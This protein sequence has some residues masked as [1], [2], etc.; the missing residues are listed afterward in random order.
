MTTTHSTGDDLSVAERHLA[1]L[2][3]RLEVDAADRDL[4]D[5]AYRIIETPVGDVMVAAT[6]RG[7]VRVA[8]RVEGFDAVLTSLAARISPRVMSAPRRLDRVVGQLDEY[9][10]GT[11]RHFDVPLDWALSTGFRRIVHEH[12]PHIEFGT[13]TTY[14]QVA[15]VVGNPKAVRAVGSACATNPLPIVIPCHRVLRA[16]GGLGGYLGGEEAKADLLA[17]ESGRIG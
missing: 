3:A 16:D 10:A 5:V 4:L 1:D 9:F 6:T 7:L 17:L 8:F 13:T 11:R 14:S 12:L 15:I 2:H